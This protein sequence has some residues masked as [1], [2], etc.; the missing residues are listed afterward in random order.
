MRIAVIT[1]PYLPNISGVVVFARQL[2][3][4]LKEA[5]H[6]VIIL[7][8]S[9]TR[10]PYVETIEGITVYRIRSIPNPWRRKFR[11]VVR[12]ERTVNRIL[13][14][15][16]PDVI[17]VQDPGGSGAA[18]LKYAKKNGIPSIGTYHFTLQFVT[19]YF[20]FSRMLSNNWKPLIRMY[21]NNFYNECTVITCPTET[22]RQDLLEQGLIP[23]VKVISNGIETSSPLSIQQ[24]T[25][26]GDGP[27]KL[28]FV[29]RIDEDKNI[30]MLLRAFPLIL[31]KRNVKLTIVGQGNKLA[32]Y[33]KW[34]SKHGLDEYIH[35]TGALTPR[36]DEIVS[37]Y[38]Q[39]HVFVMPSLIET[40]SIVTMEA[41]VAAMPIVAARAGALPELIKN[42]VNGMLVWPVTAR[43]F[44]DSVVRMLKDETA[45]NAM[46]QVARESVQEH[47][48]E[49]TIE[50]FVDLYREVQ[51]K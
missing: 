37:E 43:A 38:A 1:E 11:L 2:A 27:V 45:A 39:A 20:P 10:K 44:A 30:P 16:N 51:K 23:Q 35:F 18:S 4:G 6:D 49:K 34:V 13:Q 14:S 21:C 19:H 26:W 8:A 24:R 9:P 31:A 46:G 25:A 32:A 5:G 50:R 28:L 48:L 3:V 29:G 40:Q 36:G 33:E 47:S 7:S 41:M 17:H 22:V 42:G 15:F 12:Q